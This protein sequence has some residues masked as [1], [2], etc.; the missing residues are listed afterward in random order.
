MRL[1]LLIPLVAGHLLGDFVLQSDEMV[2]RRGSLGVV[3]AHCLIVALVSWA[4]TGHFATWWWLVPALFVTH[5]A[6][7]VTKDALGKRLERRELV[8]FASD[9]MAHL[10]VLVLLTAAVTATPAL[11]RT[12]IGD[13]LW[14]ELAGAR[15]LR[16]LTLVSGWMLVALA[17]GHFLSLLLRRFEDE[18]SEAQKGGLPGGGYWIG[19]TERSLIYLFILIGEP[20]GIGFLAAAKSVFRIGELK[21]AEDRK[22]A[23]YILIGTLVSFTVAMVIG[24]LTRE[25]VRALA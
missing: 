25:V 3:L 19:V 8:L 12:A 5:L 16:G 13:G 15:Y 2:R 4:L 7:D 23:E 9:Q 22:L 14:S 1:D 6:I 11:A 20:S 21:E 17:S 10:V 18:L 24:L